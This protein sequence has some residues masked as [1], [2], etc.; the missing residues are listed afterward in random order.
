MLNRRDFVKKTISVALAFGGSSSVS[1]ASNDKKDFI[2]KS[3]W[4]REGMYKPNETIFCQ[5]DNKELLAVIEKHAKE[6]GCR[7]YQGEPGTHDIL[8]AASYFVAIVDRNI[9][10]EEIWDC[11]S[12]YCNYVN[13]TKPIIF[14]DKLEIGTLPNNKWWIQY[15]EINN[16]EIV[17]YNHDDIVRHISEMFDQASA[18]VVQQK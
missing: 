14:L 11:Y 4:I 12:D 9:V 5:F 10:G 16:E 3:A 2:Y 15:L 1:S 6:L 7:V 17:R 13:N 8:A 18:W